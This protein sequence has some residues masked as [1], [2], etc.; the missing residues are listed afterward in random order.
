MLP[1]YYVGEAM[2]RGLLQVV[3][4]GYELDATSI[5]AV[6]LSR[7]HQPLA[8]RRLIGFLA[9]RFGGD[10]APWDRAAAAG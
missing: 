1:T 9:E 8:L 6:Y 3:L 5:H 4:P 10:V 7:R 2:S